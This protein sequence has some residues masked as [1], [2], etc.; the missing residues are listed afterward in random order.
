MGVDMKT[1][2]LGFVATAV[3]MAAGAGFLQAQERLTPVPDSELSE[4]EQA[5]GDLG[6]LSASLRDLQPDLRHPVGFDA[7]YRV[8]GRED[9]LMRVSGGLYAVFPR[10]V[11]AQT[12]QGQIPLIPYGTTFFIGPP[13]TSAL[14]QEPTVPGPPPGQVLGDRYQ[15]RQPYLGLETLPLD[16]RVDTAASPDAPV[17]RRA[18]DPGPP[19]QLTRGPVQATPTQHLPPREAGVPVIRKDAPQTIATDEVYRSKR[20]AELVRRAGEKERMKDEG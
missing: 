13:D 9:L 8:P 15:A 17:T 5:V 19:G 7:V 2:T 10:S 6:P 4:V 12:Q 18:G 11:Y 14:P 20:L 3:T 16:L 1:I